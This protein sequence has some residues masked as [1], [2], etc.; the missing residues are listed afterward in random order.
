MGDMQKPFTVMQL[1]ERWSCSRDAVYSMIRTG[2]LK[3][4]PLGGKLLRV[5]AEE[6]KRWESGGGNTKSD[7][8]GSAALAI[9]RSQHGARHVSAE[10]LA[11][12]I[13]K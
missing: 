9:K 7:N 10:D 1:A 13:L 8:T 11:L 5:T 2:K 4:F 3:A 12:Q 6:V